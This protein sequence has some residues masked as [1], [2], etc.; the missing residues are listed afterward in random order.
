MTIILCLICFTIYARIQAVCKKWQENTFLKE[1]QMTAYTL[2]PKI[3]AKTLYLA[4]FQS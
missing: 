4:L 3:P 2:G 1:Y